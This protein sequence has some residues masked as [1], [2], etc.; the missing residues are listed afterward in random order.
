MGEEQVGERADVRQAGV[1]EVGVQVVRVQLDHG[2]A[3]RDGAVD[4]GVD[5]VADVLRSQ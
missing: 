2:H 4:V 3:R 5:G 1:V